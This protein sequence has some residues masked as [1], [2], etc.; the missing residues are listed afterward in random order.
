MIIN[1]K[2]EVNN[3]TVSTDYETGECCSAGG[4][5]QAESAVLNTDY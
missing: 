1:N 4:T 2:I 3:I 5:F